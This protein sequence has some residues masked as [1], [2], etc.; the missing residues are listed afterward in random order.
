MPPRDNRNSNNC[1]GIIPIKRLTTSTPNAPRLEVGAFV[2]YAA[3][4]S[5]NY[6]PRYVGENTDMINLFHNNCTGHAIIQTGKRNGG[7]RCSN[8]HD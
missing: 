6:G 4:A 5:D 3:I 1:T 7:L 2:R 8:C